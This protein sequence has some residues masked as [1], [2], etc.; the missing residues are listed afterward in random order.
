MQ[1]YKLVVWV[2]YSAQHNVY[3]LHCVVSCNGLFCYLHC[4]AVQL[5]SYR[6]QGGLCIV[7]NDNVHCMCAEIVPDIPTA[8]IVI[9]CPV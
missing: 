3:V 2:E 6:L 9:A 7:H 8:A 5:I 4:Y 1:L